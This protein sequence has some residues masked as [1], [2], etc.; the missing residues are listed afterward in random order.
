[1]ARVARF[2]TWTSPIAVGMLAEKVVGLD[3]P[4]VDGEDAYWVESRPSEGGR[5]AL[6]RR[7]ASGQVEDLLPEP[8]SAR[9]LV[10]EYGGLCVA[11]HSGTVYFSSYADQRLYRAAPGCA[12]VPITPEPRSPGALRYAAPSVALGGAWLVCVRE[13]HLGPGSPGGPG[14]GAAGVVNDLVAV[15]CDGSGEHVLA[16]GRDFFGTPA[17]SP[18][19][20]RV[21]WCSWDLPAMPW[22]G[23]ELYEATLGPDAV[24]GPARLVAGG[25]SESITQPR[26]SNEGLLHFVSDRSGW[27]NLYADAGE[28]GGRGI[29]PMEAELAGPDWVFGQATYAFLR[30]GELVATWSAAGEASLGIL[31]PGGAGF[32]TLDLPFT[33]FRGLRPR[34]SRILAI[35]GSPTSCEALVLIDLETCAVEVL[36]ESRSS[37]VD[38]RY[39]SRPRHLVLPSG[40]AGPR[41]APAGEERAPAEVHVLFYPPTNPELEAPAGE[42]PP[43]LVMVHGGPTA[44]VSSV[45]DYGLQFWTSRGFAVAAV[46]YG[47]SSGYGRAYRE[48]LR[49]S[50]GIVDRADVEAA[51]LGLADAGLVD[52]DRLLVRGGS[53]G[54]YTVLC[55]LT[56]GSAFAAGTSRYGVADLGALARETHKFESRYLDG[57]VGPWPE[58]QE[59]YEERS[60]LFHSELIRTPLLVLQGLEDRIVPPAQAEAIV[61]ALRDAGVPVAYLAFEGEQH[62]FRRAETIERAASAELYF[63]GRVLGFEPADDL[64]AVPIDNAGAL[65]APR[66]AG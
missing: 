18:D 23:T 62:G 41:G 66:P 65:P 21:A 45:L 16:G 57:L 32:E 19:G 46:D 22:D 9:T 44:S 64:E 50:W 56:F 10:H 42:R 11:V 8:W 34:G 49:G 39:L 60:P 54:G 48:R 20:R 35:A 59:V 58:A 17:V 38:P 15:A 3:D 25:P 24:A 37:Q 55:C 43:L 47:G 5:R 63:Y 27:W 12:P 28:P 33:S 36:R 1:M 53:A 29:A 6:V 30:S 40:P 31:R 14:G 2:G 13:R 61:E 52:R 51:A 26:Y 7:R 4:L